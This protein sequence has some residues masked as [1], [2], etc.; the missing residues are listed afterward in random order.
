MASYG[1][2]A[3]D[4]MRAQRLAREREQG[5]DEADFMKKKLSDQLKVAN[6]ESK[7]ASTYDAVEQEIK[8]STV[9][10][11]TIE[12]MKQT[13]ERARIERD[14]LVALKDNK[15]KEKEMKKIKEKEKTKAKQKAKIKALSFNPDDDE[16]EGEDE[17]ETE[18]S[19]K[20]TESAPDDDERKKK[21]FGMNPE[22]NTAFLPDRD[23]DEQENEMREKLRVQW[24]ENQKKVKEE[25]VEITYSY[26]DGSG[27]RKSII[28]KKGNS[29]YQFLCKVLEKIRSEFPE[30]KTVTGDQ[31]MY[32]KEDLIIPQTNT[33]YDFIV[34]RA[35]G[36][37]GPLF[38]FDVK[39]DIRLL[40]DATVEKE[41]SHA[42]KVV[43]RSFY[44]R[45]KHIF[46]ASRWE[47]FDP[48]KDYAMEQ[49]EKR[50]EFKRAF[51]EDEDGVLA[52]LAKKQAPGDVKGQCTCSKAQ[53]CEM[54][55]SASRW[56]G[57]G[58]GGGWG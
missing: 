34:S 50:G 3:A 44:D 46:P 5:K 30:L 1:G 26:W 57:V 7:F 20:K 4:G 28:M 39:E 6:I 25:E 18:K 33:F 9:G 24:E 11:V 53:V 31:L 52:K 12:Q 41:E 51:G 36:K 56:G 55:W 37:T 8:A 13:Q 23:R 19:S 42:G 22:V 32:V 58:G 48:T 45:N 15:Q 38:N 27:H 2:Q 14:K 29:I 54:H 16:E 35:R 40:H 49:R 21:R 47:P 17:E 43:L 10:L